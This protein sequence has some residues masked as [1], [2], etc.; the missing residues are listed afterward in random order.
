MSYWAKN[1][2]RARSW[3]ARVRK[4]KADGMI[5]ASSVVSGLAVFE[6][7]QQGLD[8]VHAAIAPSM[9]KT[10]DGCSSGALQA[11]QIGPLRE[12]VGR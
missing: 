12:E 1:G 5:T 2:S 6:L 7:C 9:E 3:A 4:T 8:T 10:P 11:E